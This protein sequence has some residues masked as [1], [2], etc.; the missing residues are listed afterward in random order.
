MFIYNQESYDSEGYG[1]GQMVF[2]QS[3]ID[4]YALQELKGGIYALRATENIV[5]SD[6]HFFNIGIISHKYTSLLNWEV[7]TK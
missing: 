3:I 5:D 1:E 6:E 4:Y 2:R 7:T